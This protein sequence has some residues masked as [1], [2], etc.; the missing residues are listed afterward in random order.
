MTDKEMQDVKVRLITGLYSRGDVS[1]VF[2]EIERLKKEIFK[3]KE[4][5]AKYKAERDKAVEDL[6][7]FKECAIC[8]HC[9]D[10]VYCYNN[11]QQHFDE[12][13]IRTYPKWE[14][15]GLEGKL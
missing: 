7:K 8:K 4:E 5:A 2:A 11:C 13:G 9:Q 1:M 12:I 10:Q 3:Y 6:S 14:W 15:R